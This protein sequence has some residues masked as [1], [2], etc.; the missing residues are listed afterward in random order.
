M[1]EF[2]VAWLHDN[3]IRSSL[4]TLDRV[5]LVVAF[6]TLQRFYIV[7]QEKSE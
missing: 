5:R 3:G 7:V 1:A 4:Q 6:Q 2:I